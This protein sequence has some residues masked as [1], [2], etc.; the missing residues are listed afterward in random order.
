MRKAFFL[1]ILILF[2]A[3]IGETLYFLKDGF[4]ARRIQ[5]LSLPTPFPSDPESTAALAQTYRYLGR[6]RQCFAFASEDN[7]YVL[8]LPRTDI[9]KTPLWVRLLPLKAYQQRLEADHLERQQFILDSFLL[10]FHELPEQTG[11]L[12]LHLGQSAAPHSLTLIDALGCK[13]SISLGKTPFALQRK[14]PLWLP[15]FSAAL[16]NNRSEAKRLLDALLDVIVERGQKGILNRDRSFRRNYGFDGTR[17][18]QIDVGSFF[19]KPELSP[20]AT[21]QKSVRDSVDPIQEWLAQ[22]DP[23]MLAYLNEQLA[24]KLESI[25]AFD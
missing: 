12:A 8:K 16:A 2:C 7:R 20:K 17:A 18:Y 25:F 1:L 24:L 5:S 9:Y 19:R 21:F 4:S 6:G 10:S 22:T 3:A 23:Q 15:A 14:Q 11:L 13:H